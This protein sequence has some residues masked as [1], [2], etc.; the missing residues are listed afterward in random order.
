MGDPHDPV[1]KR[2]ADEAEDYFLH[3]QPD[4]KALALFIGP[5]ETREFR[6]SMP[7]ESRI[8]YG[9]PLVTPLLWLIDEYEPYLIV[10]VDQEKTSILNATLGRVGGETR[11]TNDVDEYD[12]Q[13]RTE[14]QLG[15]SAQRDCRDLYEKMIDE[16]RMRY[17]R[18][19]VDAID[20][21]SQKRQFTRILFGGAEES[22]KTVINLLPE[23]LAGMVVGWLPIPM[24]SDPQAIL[25][26]ATPAALEHERQHEMQIVDEIINF[27]KS[28][29]RGALGFK[30][31]MLAL[32]EQRVELLVIP[33][34]IED[35]SLAVDLPG[36]VRASSGT[37]ELVHGE[38][39]ELLRLEG[40]I[41]ARLYYAIPSTGNQ[42]PPQKEQ[43]S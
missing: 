43:K 8:A 40:G 41:G 33:Y 1:W 23:R 29:G 27:A 35:E 25:E 21:L 18:E 16:H 13:E 15:A 6:L 32:E 2:Q 26:R 4:G 31:V 37:I 12:F 36:Q 39:A 28:K 11:L 5:E 38:A 34:P 19:V 14:Y 7:L 24:R 20:K 10:L 22:A 3:Y 30:D 9:K 42:V 17:F